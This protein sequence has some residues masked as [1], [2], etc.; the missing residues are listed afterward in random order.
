MVHDDDVLD[1][2]LK[3]HQVFSVMRA[4]SGSVHDDHARAYRSGTCFGL[5]MLEGP[6]KFCIKVMKE[7]MKKTESNDIFS[8]KYDQQ[9]SRMISMWP[10]AADD[11]NIRKID[12]VVQRT[13][14]VI[15]PG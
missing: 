12:D 9:W 6:F 2:G 3:K 14:I 8:K 4:T 11:I 13:A 7:L 1:S 10:C 15:S 5:N